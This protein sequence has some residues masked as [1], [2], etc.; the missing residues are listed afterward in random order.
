MDAASTVT[1]EVGLA[2]HLQS[3]TRAATAARIDNNVRSVNKHTSENKPGIPPRLTLVHLI[4]SRFRHRHR[5]SSTGV[6]DPNWRGAKLK[7]GGLAFLEG[8]PCL[9]ALLGMALSP[10]PERPCTRGDKVRE[11]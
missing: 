2:R 4:F 5:C 9:R 11:A 6:V 3:N 10:S 1:A 8:T 7:A